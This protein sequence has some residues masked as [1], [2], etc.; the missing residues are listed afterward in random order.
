M[1]Y[2]SPK[3]ERKFLEV[4]QTDQ[5]NNYTLIKKIPMKI[6]YKCLQVSMMYIDIYVNTT[7]TIENEIF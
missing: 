2:I 6:S 5:K 1:D 7:T 3:Q 4:F